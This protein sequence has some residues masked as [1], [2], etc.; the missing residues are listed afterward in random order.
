MGDSATLGLLYG[1]CSNRVLLSNNMRDIKSKNNDEMKNC[2]FFG[3]L[4]GF[5]LY[6]PIQFFCS[7]IEESVNRWNRLFGMQMFF[8]N[9]RLCLKRIMIHFIYRTFIIVMIY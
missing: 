3:N 4:I 6:K 8:L 5:L 9:K 7:G 2:F 1:S